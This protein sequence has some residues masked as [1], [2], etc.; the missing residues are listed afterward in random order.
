MRY[1]PGFDRPGQTRDGKEISYPVKKDVLP[2]PQTTFASIGERWANVVNT[3][4]RYAKAQSYEGGVRTP[5]IVYWPKNVKAKADYRPP[6]ACDGF[7]AD[8]PASSKKHLI[9]QLTRHNITP[10]TGLSLLLAAFEGKNGKEHDALFNEHF[11]ARYIRNGN[12]KRWY[13]WQAIAC[14]HLYRINQDETELNDQAG[15]HPDMVSKMAAQWRQWA[16]THNVFS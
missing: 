11:N 4:Y 6:G 14:W 10:Y 3:P 13:P 16:N 15:Q 7:Y 12:W 1:G 2:G 8:I 9:L 5:M